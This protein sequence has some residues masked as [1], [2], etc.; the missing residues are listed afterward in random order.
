MGLKPLESLERAQYR[1]VMEPDQKAD[2]H[3]PFLQI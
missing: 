2:R 3:L 1:M